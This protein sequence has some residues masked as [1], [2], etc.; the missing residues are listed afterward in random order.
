[1]PLLGS[2]QD[3]PDPEGPLQPAEFQQLATIYA[4]SCH[5]MLEFGG[6]HAGICR[7]LLAQMSEFAEVDYCLPHAG[8]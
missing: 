6:S 8:A 7:T 1:L 4:S 3:S 5:P 2:N